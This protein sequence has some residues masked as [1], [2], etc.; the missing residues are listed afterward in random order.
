MVG[1]RTIAGTSA[2]AAWLSSDGAHWSGPV[3]VPDFPNPSHAVAL[4]TGFL[5]I[6]DG[7]SG[8][9]PRLAVVAASGVTTV[10]APELGLRTGGM[11]WG[12][13]PYIPTVVILSDQLFL[14]RQ[15]PAGATLWRTSAASLGGDSRFSRVVGAD[16][17]LLG[18]SVVAGAAGSTGA[19]LL[20]FDRTTLARFALTSPDGVVWTRHEL[21]AG[22]LGG[23]ISDLLIGTST[24]YLAVGRAVTLA[25]AADDL[26]S[27][28]DGASWTPVD[29]P[30][31]QP[32][33]VDPGPCPARPSTLAAL[34]KIG[35]AKAAGCFGR[36]DLT[37][38]AYVGTCGGC[39]G[40]SNYRWIPDWLGGM[41][42]PLYLAADFATASTGMG[43][44]GPAWPDPT[45]HLAIPPEKTP[46]TVT[47]HYEDP[48]SASCRVVP[49]GA[50]V[51]SLPSVD[52]AVTS[53][54]RSL[55]VTGIAVRR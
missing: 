14:V 4:P 24:G 25:G 35:A 20:G 6:D 34:A 15:D 22:A 55:V 11:T 51:A 26:W 54:R 37:I 31:G 7:A 2:S 41:F 50:S 23:G 3:D 43:D 53:C 13:G 52:E 48:A 49:F 33:A 38:S 27:S 17:L 8:S 46:V 9:P 16:A 29:A 30:V 36:S 19:V 12:D 42:A 28:A 44:V 39:G 21:A 1:W 18:A 40:T 5:L 47:G 10:P 45:R 32:P